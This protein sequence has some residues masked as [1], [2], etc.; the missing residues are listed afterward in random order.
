MNMSNKKLK[1]VCIVNCFDT[2]EHRVDLL[3]DYFLKMG[4]KVRVITSDYRHFEKSKRTDSK[5][6]FEFIEAIPYTKNM[7]IARMKSHVVLSKSIFERINNEKFDLLW[8]L[9]PPN[10]FVK[11]G[12]KYKKE[13]VN[14]KLIFD[15]IDLWPETMPISKLKSLPPFQYWRNLRDR[16][17]DAADSIVTE[18]NLF[19]QKLPKNIAKEK[20]HTVYLARKIS[21]YNSALTMPEDKIS[22]CYLGSI[23]NI[24]DIP[25]IVDLINGLKVYKPVEL[26][27]IGDGEK[28]GILIDS[29]EEAGAEVLYHGRVYDTEEKQRIFNSCHYGL[30]IMKQTVFIGLT[31]KSMDYF[32]AGLPIINNIHGDTWDMVDLYKLGHNIVDGESLESLIVY[33]LN[34]RKAVRSNYES[35]FSIEAFELKVSEL[36]R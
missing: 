5:D 36:I 16:N 17:L 33:D 29:C 3:H 2:Y 27:I 8:V 7:S 35:K 25:A 12:A 4:A 34:M 32:E 26:H 10:S 13:H 11:D 18:C 30:N 19:H 9:V 28:R 15:L 20:V 23:N 24:I 14:T 31:M 1:S 21:P 22:L 6:D